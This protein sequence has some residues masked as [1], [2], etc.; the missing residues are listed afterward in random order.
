MTCQ[1]SDR[2]IVAM[3]PAKAGGAKGATNQQLTE[4]KHA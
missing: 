2:F 3:K 4:V 1:K